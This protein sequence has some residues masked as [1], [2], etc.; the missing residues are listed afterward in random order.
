MEE[1]YKNKSVNLSYLRII[2][3]IA[4]VVAHSWSTLTNNPSM[5]SLTN[6]EQVILE[7]GWNLTK[8]EIP[9]FFM[10]SGAIFL[11]SNKH[12]T[13][14]ESFTKYSKRMLLALIVFG[15]PYALMEIFFDTRI[16][17]IASIFEA[18]IRV[19]NGQSFGHLWYMYT[20]IGLYLFIPFLK[21]IVD[22]IDNKEYIAL[23]LI[24]FVYNFF[25]PFINELVGAQIAFI[26]PIN[27]YPVFYLL[28][29]N[30][31]LN[32][33]NCDLPIII[34]IIAVLVTLLIVILVVIER[35]PFLTV[36]AY[37]SPIDA[38]LASSIFI[39][40]TKKRKDMTKI[41]WTIDRLCFGVY[42]VHPVFIHFTYKFLKITPLG[43]LF[44]MKSILFACGFIIVSFFASWI[45]QRI[46]PLKKYIL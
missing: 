32:R 38:V 13:L 5:F 11:N 46:K 25:F 34:P 41:V 45:M 17:S 29:G 31:L 30:Y 28:L 12:F 1:I 6:Q 15:V 23:L 37:D 18:F 35:G 44:F 33:K 4:V 8:W 3:T 27:T 20:L 14:R 2:S 16:I 21:V 26:Y 22:K 19:L 39:L 36:M 40:F 7:L 10:I 24:L 9:I 42:L 43:D